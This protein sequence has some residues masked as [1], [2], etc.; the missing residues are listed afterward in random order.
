MLGQVYLSHLEFR[1]TQPPRPERRGLG[2]IDAVLGIMVWMAIAAVFADY[3]TDHLHTQRERAELQQLADWQDTLETYVEQN[4]S[5][6]LNDAFSTPGRVL[7]VSEATLQAANSSLPNTRRAGVEREI[8]T[9]LYAP[10]ATELIYFTTAQGNTPRLHIPDPKV[11]HGNIGVV[12]FPRAG[13]LLGRGVDLDVAPIRAS[14]PTLMQYGD[15]VALSYI[16]SSADIRPYLSRIPAIVNGV[17]LTQMATDL[18]M[19]GHNITATGSIEALEGSLDEITAGSVTMRGTLNANTA[20]ITTV[21]ASG[22]IAAQNGTFQGDV[23]ANSL[24]TS[25]SI[26]AQNLNVIGTLSA[27]SL[28]LTDTLS[29]ESATVTGLLTGDTAVLG[30]SVVADTAQTDTL[31]TNTLAVTGDLSTSTAF[32]QNLTTGSCSGC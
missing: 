1:T 19:G 8:S 28:T 26:S 30:D 2:L 10:S 15:V 13:R 5:A 7:E 16:N 4:P 27:G 17:D 14:D 18:D 23:N 24:S 31:E 21:T 9:W 12:G 29:A 6:R 20:S 3:Y 11:E 32:T 22:Q 25:G